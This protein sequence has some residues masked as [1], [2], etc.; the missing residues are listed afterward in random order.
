M[1]D[2]KKELVE[3]SKLS[4]GMYVLELDQPW[5]GTPFM[6]QGFLL[7]NEADLEKLIAISHYV[8]IDR[9]RSISHHFAAPAKINVA[10]KREGA[11]MRVKNPGIITSSNAVGIS[12]NKKYTDKT[13]FIDILRDLRN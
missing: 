8:Y 5:E 2:I 1:I 9:T 3:V 6:L 13:S 11:I 7:D 12:N 10:L 4:L